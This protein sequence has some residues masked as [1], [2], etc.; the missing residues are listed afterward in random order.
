V[1]TDDVMP[2]LSHAT[3]LAEL[4]DAA[5]DAFEHVL[6]LIREHDSP[7]CEL[8]VPMML[9]GASAASG[10]DYVGMA[11]ALLPLACAARQTGTGAGTP[12][13]SAAERIT[14]ICR[15]LVLA[16]A[17]AEDDAATPEDRRACSHAARCAEEISNLLGGQRA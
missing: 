4:L 12:T 8:F 6:E 7:A 9:A 16:L 1:N 15:L 13:G 14:T 5:Y 10:R 2:R 17:T 11:P 3:G